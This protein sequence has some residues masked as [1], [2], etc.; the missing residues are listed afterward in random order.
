MNYTA[1]TYSNI[2]PVVFY[3]G[4]FCGGVDPRREQY[5][6]EDVAGVEVPDYASKYDALQDVIK[7]NYATFEVDYYG[8]DNDNYVDGEGFCCGDNSMKT[9]SIADDSPNY[10]KLQYY[11]HS[12][13]LGSAS[14]ITNLD[15]E[16]VQHTEYVPF[17]EVFLEERNNT[18]NTPFLFNGKELDEETGLYYY[19]ARYY[20]PKTS[21][22]LS[23]DKYAEKYP[24]ASPYQYCLN[25]PVNALEINGDSIWITNRTGFLG[26]GRKQTVLYEDGNLYNKDGSAYEGEQ[27]KFLG[28]TVAALDKI[29]ETKTGE[30]MVSEVQNSRFNV[31]IKRGSSNSYVADNPGKAA[32]NIQAPG[33]FPGLAGSGGTIKFN[34]Q[35]TQGGMTTRGNRDSQPFIGLAHE[36]AHS[37][38][39]I[40]GNLNLAKISGQDF[41]YS[42]HFATHIENKIRAEN[43]MPLRTHY[44]Y[45]QSTNT[46][47]YR[48][49]QGGQSIFYGNNYYDH[50]MLKPIIA[51]IPVQTITPTIIMK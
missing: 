11:Y 15:G 9:K 43:G 4:G 39:G 23:T 13:H 12:D 50:L 19:G 45:N 6:G 51:P 22:F 25:N 46:G 8:V 47:F 41:T 2:N 7:D 31:T 30:Q 42:E 26:L 1:A 32:L 10:E 28:N 24:A 5:A 35:S 21:Q 37:W 49:L 14:Y 27:T 36:M 40:G 18:W 44:G 34:P 3:G 38:D 17:G 29:R 33:Q 20:N 16:V 48:I